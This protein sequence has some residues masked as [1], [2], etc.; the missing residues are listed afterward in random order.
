[1]D[2]SFRPVWIAEQQE[3]F[4]FLLARCVLLNPINRDFNYMVNHLEV[5]FQGISL[6]WIHKWLH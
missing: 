2:F 5:D 1:V 6:S 3:D 4:D